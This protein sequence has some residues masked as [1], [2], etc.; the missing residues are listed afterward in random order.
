MAQKTAMKRRYDSDH[1]DSVGSSCGHFHS[2]SDVEEYIDVETVA[3]GQIRAGHYVDVKTTSS[4]SSLDKTIA[5]RAPASRPA[6]KFRSLLASVPV[7]STPRITLVG[8]GRPESSSATLLNTDRSQEH[9]EQVAGTSSATT[10]KPKVPILSNDGVGTY[11]V[12]KLPLEAM[13]MSTR[14]LR[15]IQEDHQ[16][17]KMHCEEDQLE[18]VPFSE[19]TSE[20]EAKSVPLLTTSEPSTSTATTANPRKKPRSTNLLACPHTQCSSTFSCVDDLVSHLVVFHCQHQFR[21]RK[22]TFVTLEKYEAWKTT[23]E[24]THEAKMVAYSTEQCEGVAQV[25]CCCE[26]SDGFGELSEDRDGRDCGKGKQAVAGCPAHFTATI[27]NEKKSAVI[28]GCLAHFHEKKEV[29]PK[30]KPA[31][32]SRKPPPKKAA[33]VQCSYCGKWYPS[34]ELMN[35]HVKASHPTF[36]RGPS[37]ECGDPSCDVVCD[38]M[39]TLCEHVAQEHGREDLIIEEF[40]FSDASKFRTWKKDVETRT[41]SKYVLSS[42]RTRASGVVQSYYLCHLS[43][44]ANRT[45][46]PAPALGRMRATKKLGRY[47]TA[48]MNTKELKD[49]TITVHCCLGHFGHGYDVRRLPLPNS[50]K[51]EITDL[52]LKGASTDTVYC[53]IRSKHSPS[54]RGYYLQR[55]EVRNIADK[56]RKQGLLTPKP[57]GKVILEHVQ[58]TMKSVVRIVGSIE[59]QDHPVQGIRFQSIRTLGDHGNRGRVVRLPIGKSGDSLEK[60]PG[61]AV[62]Q[63]DFDHTASSATSSATSSGVN[64]LRDVSPPIIGTSGYVEYHGTSEYGED[65]MIVDEGDTVNYFVDEEQHGNL[66]DVI[67]SERDS[68]SNMA[69]KVTPLLMEPQ[70]T[71]NISF[72]ESMTEIRRRIN[73]LQDQKR[74]THD[75]NKVKLLLTQIRDLQAQLVRG[76]PQTT[77]FL[78]VTE[79]EFDGEEDGEDVQYERM[80]YLSV[81]ANFL[82]SD[83]FVAVSFSAIEGDDAVCFEVEV[84]SSEAPT[85]GGAPVS[86]EQYEELGFEAEPYEEVVTS[87]Y[88]LHDST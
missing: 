14:A 35:R 64:Q 6:A 1:G 30:R 53:T 68:S 61:K 77:G 55:Y 46:N 79:Q 45:R 3:S 40:K 32:S 75:A 48:F 62:E 11:V 16:V 52:L 84:E 36:T 18:R 70:P 80:S 86:V 82:L 27:D 7:R 39:S 33:Q 13:T 66:L 8:R 29:P 85:K 88:E 44:Y 76:V 28:F 31:S 20:K 21:Q 10:S 83:F 19:F 12:H 34:R 9:G 41:V 26:Y 63:S 58:S 43:G 38:R 81:V 47:C 2:D 5:G 15:A 72:D 87:G 37:I 59:K 50:V 24:R 54:E 74:R 49:G 65:D 78:Q 67:H 60:K 42:S 57:T 51:Y 69:S 4:A 23:H 56:L 22:L 73:A 17:A 25:R 71:G